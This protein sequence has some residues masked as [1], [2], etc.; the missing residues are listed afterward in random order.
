MLST[1]ACGGRLRVW[2]HW[3]HVE[4]LEVHAQW[5]P[6]MSDPKSSQI[7]DIDGLSPWWDVGTLG[8]PANWPPWALIASLGDRLGVGHDRPR[9]F[10]SLW[11]SNKFQDI[12]CTQTMRLWFRAKFPRLKPF[13]PP[14]GQAQ[15]S[16]NPPKLT[17][18]FQ[19]PRPFQPQPWPQARTDS[20]AVIKIWR[21]LTSKFYFQIPSLTLTWSSWSYLS[22]WIGLRENLQETM[23]FTI[24]DGVFRFQFSLKPTQW[25]SVLDNII[26]TWEM[27]WLQA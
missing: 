14:F 1:M 9:K 18:G 16:T 5:L 19:A 15:L 21:I 20:G 26:W 23:V 12:F 7:Y 2:C 24:E 4:L 8:H 17:L 3:T 22:H 25:L 6:E 10:R 27:G 11:S 13:K